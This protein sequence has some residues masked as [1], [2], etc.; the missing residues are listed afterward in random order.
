MPSAWYLNY[1]GRKISFGGIDAIIDGFYFCVLFNSGS[2]L[3]VL[4]SLLSCLL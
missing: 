2:I 3:Y 1:N 4:L